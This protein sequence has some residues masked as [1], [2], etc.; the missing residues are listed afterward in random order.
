MAEGRI[1]TPT[2]SAYLELLDE[3][4]LIREGYEFLDEKRL[5]LA[6]EMLRELR[7]WQERRRD[8][9]RARAEADAALRGAAARHGL[10]G[11]SVYPPAAERA[12]TPSLQRRRF[13]GLELLESADVAYDPGA[14][15]P[16]VLPSPEAELCRRRYAGLVTRAAVLAVHEANLRRLAREYRRTERRARALENVLLP[17]ID[18]D[19]ASMAEQLEAMDQEE[20]VRVRLAGQR[21][22]GG[23]GRTVDR[24]QVSP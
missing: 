2:R 18:G 14:S 12:W 5:V 20:S 23:G 6:Q 24:G 16:P 21:R 4:R 19:L 9:Q 15:P 13:L 11:L 8:W 3:R 1:S 7:A 10:D 22:E 17:E